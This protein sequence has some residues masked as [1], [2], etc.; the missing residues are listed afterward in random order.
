MTKKQQVKPENIFRTI[1]E[2]NKITLNMLDEILPRVSLGTLT[3]LWYSVNGRQA[4]GIYYDAIEMYGKLH[5]K[6]WKI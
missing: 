6:G 1:M 3:G 4:G 5:R 2:N